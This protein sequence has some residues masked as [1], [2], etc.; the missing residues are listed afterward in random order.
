MGSLT[1]VGVEVA[2]TVL[3]V[4]SSAVGGGRSSRPA[5]LAAG[6]PSATIPSRR[7]RAATLLDGGDPEPGLGSGIKDAVGRCGELTRLGD[8]LRGQL[9]PHVGGQAAQEEGEEDATGHLPRRQ[10]G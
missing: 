5:A 10:Q 2:E 8:V 6:R 9:V 4:I 3:P 7:G 1:E